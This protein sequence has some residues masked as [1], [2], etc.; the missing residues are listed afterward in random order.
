[1]RCS[2]LTEKLV[3][4][5]QPEDCLSSIWGAAQSSACEK[6]VPIM[7]LLWEM[8]AALNVPRADGHPRAVRQEWRGAKPCQA[9]LR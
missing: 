5:L 2:N 3:R 7:E 1:M 4:C 9:Q 8:P 6:P